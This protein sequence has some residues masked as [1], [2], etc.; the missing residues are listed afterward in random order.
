MELKIQ[1]YSFAVSFAYGVVFYIML[2]INSRFIYSSFKIVKV[3]LSCLFVYF[4]SILY[5]IALLFINNG[6]IHIYFFLCIICGYIVCKVIK[7]KL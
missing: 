6:Y 7:N 5:F 4:M 3:L 1:L 2:D